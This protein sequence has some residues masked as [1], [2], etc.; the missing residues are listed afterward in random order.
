MAVADAMPAETFEDGEAFSSLVNALCDMSGK[1]QEARRLFLSMN[2][3]CI[4]GVYFWQS[5]L[6][7]HD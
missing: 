3:W 7:D 5:R 4:G 1:G 6:L 2:V